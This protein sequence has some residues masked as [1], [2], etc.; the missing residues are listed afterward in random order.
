VV[1][2]DEF[3]YTWFNSWMSDTGLHAFQ[4]QTWHHQIEKVNLLFCIL[5]LTLAGDKPV[6][7]N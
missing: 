5:L 2:N 3:H 7:S 6:P 1:E 4:E